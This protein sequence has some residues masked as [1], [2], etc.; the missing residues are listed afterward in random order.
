M[1]WMKDLKSSFTT[2]SFRVG[3]YSAVA[4][5]IVLAMIVV[6]NLLVGGLPASMTQVD[7]SYNQ[8]YTIS[9][10]S[11]KLLSSLEQDVTM[12]WMVQAGAEDDTVGTFLERYDVYPRISVQKMDPDIYP[13]FA[14][15]YA[16]S[17][18]N[19]SVIVT[20]GDRFRYVDY[21]E[22]Y[23]EDYTNYYTTGD[24]EYS[25]DG[26]NALTGA[27]D[28]VSSD[29]L[30]KVYIL[31]G[32]GESSLSQTFLSA[33]DNDNI[34]TAELSLL[35]VEAVPEDADMILVNAPE[36]DLSQE[37]T[38]RLQ[39]Y[40]ADGGNM[41]LIT[42]PPE[43][44]RLTNLESLTSSYGVTAQDGIVVEGNQNNSI[45]GNPFY[46]LPALQTH[47]I[48]D[49]L[50][51]GNYYVMLP[52]AQGLKISETLPENTTVTSLLN[53]SD[54]A[55]SKLAGYAMETYEKQD[56]DLEGGFSLGVAIT[57]T[58]GEGKQ[59]NIVWISSAE[60]VNDNVNS[61]VS[62]GNLDFFMNAINWM[63]QRE[64]RISIR[65]KAIENEY[66]TIPTGSASTM[67]LLM[68]G[69]IPLCYLGVGVYIFIRRKRR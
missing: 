43:G 49:P 4:T 37:E 36:T 45:W 57:D 54:L 59:T 46:L 67:K 30:P 5:A 7:T 33:I 11:R 31:T 14:Q 6:V 39:A 27:V 60:L 16:E 23:V 35:T 64:N 47:E 44:E 69:V 13:A 56:G 48:T 8:L 50:L 24:V 1:K 55:Y 62:G 12:Y 63:C 2:R 20:C 41:L 51:K 52:L 26:E 34:V 3:G 65:A 10:Q 29:D 61:S 42:Y 15:K 53:T 40:L 58:V 28:Y 25:F 9:E 17:L 19:N 66:L 68:L 38:E 32:H 18:T 21:Y 22:I